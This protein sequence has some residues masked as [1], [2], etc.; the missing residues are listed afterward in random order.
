M[1]FTVNIP[2]VSL[3]GFELQR[4]ADGHAEITYS[5]APE[6][7]NSFAVVHGG[8]TMTLLDVTMAHAAR[9]LAEGM[10]AVTVEMKTSFMQASQGRLRCEATVLHRTSTL[11]FTEG[12]VFN[13]EGARVSHGSGTFKL[14]PR[15]PAGREVK[16]L[17]RHGP[18]EDR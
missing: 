6:H 5:P 8:V 7:M 17:Q 18:S 16:N 10:G 15:L 12:S 2:F 3:L 11:V 9:S 1:D 14:V 13:A 4:M